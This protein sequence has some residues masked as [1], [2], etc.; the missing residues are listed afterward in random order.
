MTASGLMLRL[1][2]LFAAYF[3][4]AVFGI[5]LTQHAGNV[6]PFWPPNALLLAVLLRSNFSRWPLWLGGA[7]VAAFAAN[8]LLIAEP[9]LGA[10]L[11]V[12][13]IMEVV[14]SAV[15]M[16]RFAA[17]QPITLTEGSHLLAFAAFGGIVGPATGASCAA[18]ILAFSGAAQFW[19]GWI[20]WWIADA[21]GILLFGPLFLSVDSKIL[22]RFTAPGPRAELLTI[23]LVSTGA[24][25]LRYAHS[26][27]SLGF[28][29]VPVLLWA[30]Y[31]FGIFGCSLAAA[32]YAPIAAWS[33]VHGYSR[34]ARIEFLDPTGRIQYLQMALGI[35]VLSALAV[36]HLIAQRERYAKSLAES[37]VRLRAIVD[38]AHDAYVAMDHD[39]RIVMWSPE[40]ERA[41]GWSADEA[42][43]RQL[44]Q[45]IVPPEHRDDHYRGLRRFIETGEQRVL[46]RRLELTALHRDGHEFPVELT[47]ATFAVGD[48]PFFSAF[49]RDMTERRRLE[50]M[51]RQTQK[52]EAI[53]RLAG[54]IA[55][56]FN[57]LFQVIFGNL[58]LAARRA[59]DQRVRD[60]LEKVLH[61]AERGAAVTRQLLA[62]AREQALKPEWVAPSET[63]GATASLIRQS[64]S[65]NISVETDIPSNLWATRID[66][67][68]LELALVHLGLNARDAMPAGGTLRI[69]ATNRTL[70]DSHMGLDGEYLVLEIADSGAG[71]P[72]EV[73]PRIF[74]PFFSTN[75]PAQSRGLGLR[76][77]HGF[78]YQSGGAVDVKSQ[79][80]RGTIF[81]LYLP[82]SRDV[83]IDEAAVKEP[84]A[85]ARHK[86]ATVL[87]VEDDLDV[88]EV[89]AG[90]LEECGFEV[91]LTYQGGTA[92][93]MLRRGDRVDVILSDIMMPG[94]ISGM[95]LAEEV[96][97]L[98]LQVPVLLATG[99]SDAAADAASRG[100]PI[101]T[102]PYTM[103]ELCTS[104]AELIGNK[105]NSM[106][107]A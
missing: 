89:T 63:L 2:A 13:N 56:T 97:N 33:T 20:T 70:R 15:L 104:I 72:P 57:N 18:A 31:R 17:G 78:A 61:A 48:K 50:E 77:V 107:P 93:D 68:E 49:I 46:N 52:L 103:E 67:T 74:D 32:I 85:D 101:I 28:L 62:F 8:M 34:V 40:A 21:M 58:D 95:P 37:E 7:M 19:P 43:G 54:G 55:H 41:F 90:L 36:A 91:K 39:G 38:H 76:Q 87:I 27:F 16:R 22:Q 14:V 44:A 26:T 6:A 29:V 35:T 51:L 99:Y 3:T 45:T 69:A 30:A 106:Q 82:A 80:G 75:D 60:P 81:T 12:V 94:G 86:F 11:S 105:G 88:A 66:V 64:L 4:G 42:L 102:K 47:I 53:G 23:V 71:I 1:G 100:L 98:S 84:S 83:T 96:R 92:L 5:A 10:M 24:A 65:S 9:T 73:L 25:Y 79:P 59:P